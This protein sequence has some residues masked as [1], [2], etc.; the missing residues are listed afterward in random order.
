MKKIKLTKTTTETLPKTFEEWV[1]I[2]GEPEYLYE[3]S[4]KIKRK[5][6]IYVTD[7]EEEHIEVDTEGIFTENS[8]R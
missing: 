4:P 3:V 6:D 1:E 8:N 2:H 5:L 7:C